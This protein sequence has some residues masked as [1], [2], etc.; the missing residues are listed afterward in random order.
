MKPDATAG[1][2]PDVTVI[3][4][5]RNAAAMTRVCL[6]SVAANSGSVDY[7]ILLVDDASTERP[8][9]ADL[10]NRDR[11]RTIRSDVR[12]TYS[13]ANNRAAAEARGRWLVLL[14]NDT[15]VDPGWLDAL[16]VA[17]SREESL[18]VLGNKHL[19]PD[20]GLLQHGGMAFD[21]AGFPFHLNPGIDP[22]TPSACRRRELQCVTFACAL[23]PA[24]VYRE[25]GGLDVAYRNGF[26]D[27]DFC[28]RARAAG[29]RV[30]FT[31]GSA[32]RHKGQS[33]PGRTEHDEAN[34]RLFRERWGGK[35]EYDLARLT[36]ED[37]RYD[38]AVRNRVHARPARATGLHLAIDLAESNAFTWAASELALALVRRGVRVSL[39][40]TPFVPRT[41]EPEKRAALREL[42]RSQPY[43]TWHVKWTHYWPKYLKQA[44][45]GDVNAEFFCTNYRYREENRVLDLWMRHVQLNGHRKLA[46]SGFNVDALR[47]VG[48][49][50][51]DIATVPLGYAPEID[52]HFAAARNDASEGRDLRILLVTN[53]HDLYRHGTDLA[54]QALGRAFGPNDPVVIHIRDYGTASGN[55]QLHDWIRAQPRFPRV[56][57]HE[58]FLS[59]VDLLRLYEQSDLQFAPYRGEGF[60]MKV[61]DAMA[62]GVPTLMPAFGGPM[63]FAAPG[64]FLPIPHREV[65]VGLSY[66]RDNFMLGEGA[67][68]C[69]PDVDVMADV[70][71]S[72]PGRRDELRRVGAAARNHVRPRFSWDASA[73]RLMDALQGWQ[74]CREAAVSVRRSLDEKAVSVVIP[75]KDRIEILDR[76]LEA[77]S[78]QSLPATEFELLVVNDHGDAAALSALLARHRELPIR[79]LENGGPAGPA[80]SRNLAIDR[81]RGEVVVIT[82]D[83]IVPERDFLR[84]HLDAHRRHPAVDTAFVG[85]TLWH[86]DVSP[87][88]F[89]DHITGA[90]GQQ[91]MYELLEHDQPAP[92]DRMYTSN[93]SLKRAFLADEEMLFSTRYSHA[94]YEDVELSYRLW[95]R[96]MQ[97]RFVE[98]AV[99]RHLHHI[100][101]RSFLERQRT[102]GRMLTLLALQQPSFVPNEH[103]TFLRALEFLRSWEGAPSA[104]HVD[105]DRLLED[106]LVSCE[107][108]VA[109]HQQLAA[110]ASR[111]LIEADRAEWR[112]W[113]AD[114]TGLTW[115]AI[116]ELV[117]RLGMAEEWAQRPADLARSRAWL[118]LITLPRIAGG[119][120]AIWKMPFAAP[121]FSAFLFPGSPLAYRASKFIRSLPGV[122]AG[123]VAFE[124]SGPGQWMR[125][126][127]ARLVRRG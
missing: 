29:Y 124:Q 10:S 55:R 31:P 19:Y 5:Y 21:E 84:E 54:V 90:G 98:T 14:N 82:G 11:I 69:E 23:I 61:L 81:A 68:W 86:P 59:K 77:Y 99:G 127:L 115:D 1:A 22:A 126:V 112:R 122:G 89:L 80:S 4:P 36:E 30:V 27:V 109:M 101:P 32:I 64:T 24:A 71:R 62:L 26:E 13:E 7:E 2:S 85:L 18:G 6:A 39:P 48:V 63:E 106:L 108:M 25:L 95:L 118:Q 93:C 110:P 12:V 88:P 107:A 74:A 28:L 91:F 41:I 119:P 3:I 65:P 67:Y 45:S 70:L 60:A 15:T 40:V 33:T 50:A 38:A 103:V 51:S 20:S 96:G 73:D 57:W 113:M 9:L 117:L 97:L 116:N 123:V 53:S 35:V 79:A 49:S 76:T 83:D 66:D 8:D 92:F 105:P 52:R 56:V 44:L 104:I 72:L 46:V 100:T 121:D 58:K 87:S 78:G 111:P 120:D 43:G 94:A 42:M 17:A 47:E 37:A 16:L 125:G 114:G 102:V 34:W 75:T